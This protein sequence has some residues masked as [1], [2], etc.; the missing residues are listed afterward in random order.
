MSFTTVTFKE[1]TLSKTICVEV[2]LLDTIQGHQEWVLCLWTKV[3]GDTVGSDIFYFFPTLR[4]VHDAT[5]CNRTILPVYFIIS[6]GIFCDDN[7]STW[8]FLSICWEDNT[9]VCFFPLPFRTMDFN[10]VSI[11]NSVLVGCQT[12]PV[13]RT[14]TVTVLWVAPY[15]SSK[16]ICWNKSIHV[17]FGQFFHWIGY[18]DM[19]VTTYVSIVWHG[20]PIKLS[21]R[22]VTWNRYQGI[23]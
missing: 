20:C 4:V 3:H 7:F 5:V 15:T 14:T 21:S 13:I 11:T 12:C 8:K 16:F 22:L 10:V 18:F 17:T 9:I 23:A 6:I 1:D 19:V 2:N